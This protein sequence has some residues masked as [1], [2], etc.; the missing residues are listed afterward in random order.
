MS[1]G[2]SVF[3]YFFSSVCRWSSCSTPV[4]GTSPPGSSPGQGH[5]VVLL[6]KTLNSHSAS[7]HPDVK[8]GT[9]ELY[10]GGNL[11]MD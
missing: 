8:T 9:G 11:A 2:V 5:C 7:L 6:G 10:A 4:S 3:L 1:S